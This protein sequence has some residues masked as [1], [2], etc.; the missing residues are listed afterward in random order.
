[1]RKIK[2]V[3]T[4]LAIAAL[5][6]ACDNSDDVVLFDDESMNADNRLEEILAALDKN[7]SDELENMFSKAT[8]SQVDNFQ[9][10]AETL[11]QLFEGTVKSWERTGFTSS[12][13]IEDREKTAQN[14]A[15]YDVTTDKMEYVF[16]TIECTR[17]TEQPDNVGLNTLAVVKKADE[18]S[19]F[20]YW[21]DMQISG[22]Y[23][24]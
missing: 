15:W 14:I 5:L 12:S 7:D 8:L 4:I 17:D 22:I 21:Q 13:T 9:G 16:F 20:T 1:M 2:I 24:P 19:K 18:E 3:L 11:F 23:M 10:Q 6:S